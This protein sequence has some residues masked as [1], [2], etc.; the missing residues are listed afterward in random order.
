MR[1]PSGDHAGSRSSKELEVIGF[2]SLPSAFTIQIC[3]VLSR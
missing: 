3:H 2:N 1:L